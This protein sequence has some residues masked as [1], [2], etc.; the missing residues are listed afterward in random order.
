MA[1][2]RHNTVGIA[3]VLASI[4]LLTGFFYWW[5]L[6]ATVRIAVPQ[7][8]DADR[9]MLVALGDLLRRE[10]AGIRLDIRQVPTIDEA[11]Q[12]LG[13]KDVEAAV[14]R[15]DAVPAG[16]LQT[17]ALMRREP[18]LLVVPRGRE[19]SKISDLSEMTLVVARGA[20][21]NDAFAR[22]LLFEHGVENVTLKPVQM[23]EVGAAVRDRRVGAVLLFGAPALR[24]IQDAVADIA[25]EGRG[26]PTFLPVELAEAVTGRSARFEMTE[27]PRGALG[28]GSTPR[29]TEAL[30]TTTVAVR[31][32][33][34]TDASETQ[35]SELLE[36]LLANRQRLSTLDHPIATLVEP[37]DTDADAVVPVHRGASAFLN[38][39]KRGI[40]D[41]YS[42]WFYFLLFAGSL[43]GSAF[44]GLMGLGSIRQR[45][46][47][48]EKL[49]RLAELI[50]AVRAA[51]AAGLDRIEDEASAIVGFVLDCASER[52]L[53]NNDLTA[54]QLGIDELRASIAR[55]RRGLALHHLAAAE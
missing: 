7:L 4:A 55:A 13:R 53:E 44:A 23:H 42:D 54:F 25:R 29:P 46:E 50:A 26:D 18:V 45:T 40:L 19:V 17:I 35:M 36:H 48:P 14:M 34:R 11:V 37:P 38:G 41:R 2:K 30:S 22:K 12:S 43:G 6:P 5:N 15:L 28:G 33:A 20:P 39:E 27:V 24:Q 49:A 3:A 21:S 51:D 47:T 8:A 10:G 32:M 31:L 16:R 9:R 52:I 1:L